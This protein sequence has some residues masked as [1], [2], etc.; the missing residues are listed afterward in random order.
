[1]VRISTPALR[2]DT[3]PPMGLDASWTW[4]SL[5]VSKASSCF[6][7]FARYPDRRP[8]GLTSADDG[9]LDVN[10]IWLHWGCHMN[11]SRR[12]FL[13]RSDQQG[14]TWVE[15]MR[16][17]PHRHRNR[18]R[19]HPAQR[20]FHGDTTTLVSGPTMLDTSA[21]D[22]VSVSTT[23][24]D[25]APRMRST[26]N[27]PP[28]STERFRTPAPPTPKRSPTMV[29]TF[30]RSTPTGSLMTLRAILL[31]TLSLVL[32]TRRTVPASPGKWIALRLL[33]ASNWRQTGVLRMFPIGKPAFRL[34]TRTPDH[35]GCD[36]GRQNRRPPRLR[37]FDTR[38][39]RSWLRPQC[40]GPGGPPGSDN[41]RPP[42]ALTLGFRM[43]VRGP[44][45]STRPRH[46][47]TM[48]S[49]C[50]PSMVA[51]AN[52]YHRTPPLIGPLHTPTVP[53]R[54]PEPPNPHRLPQLSQHFPSGGGGAISLTN[55]TSSPW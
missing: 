44:I 17:F 11:F 28:P 47:D 48:L 6:A 23:E 41:T 8:T 40:Q 43:Q 45:I 14:R 21:E 2:L 30:L 25:A 55:P 42:A 24:D 51:R 38:H 15:S 4:R 22:V 49:F 53:D 1:M 33:L 36:A 54:C 12:R 39:D 34:L 29:T 31:R 7:R 37:F 46:H 32:Q 19:Q 50:S 9:S 5:Q 18:K 13:L 35:A 10:H 27:Q 3:F 26:K 20:D 52:P 16:R